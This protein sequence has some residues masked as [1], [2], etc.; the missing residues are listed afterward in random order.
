MV[1][2]PTVFVLGVVGGALAELL[3]WYQLRESISF[4]AY[5][6][7]PI[8]WVITVLMILA[9]GFLAVVQGVEGSKPLLALNI[10]ISAPL[11]LKGLAATVPAQ[12]QT[13]KVLGEAPKGSVLDFV[14]GR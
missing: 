7:T 5:S 1:F 14:A 4:P 10:G 12:P 3:K 2:T 11:I 6:K 8:Y 9:G 13:K